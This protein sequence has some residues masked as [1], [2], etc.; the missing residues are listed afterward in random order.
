[1]V[2]NRHSIIAVYMM[3]SRRNGTIY[4]GVTS[5]LLHRVYQHRNELSEGFTRRHGC[6]MLVWYEI[7]DMMAAAIQREK[8]IKSYPRRW[9]LNLIE[10]QN[11]N[12]EDLWLRI[13]Q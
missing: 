6:K 10:A 9:K 2:L 4:T 7:H 8:N 3:A 12:W 5:A 1:M 13:A 11:P